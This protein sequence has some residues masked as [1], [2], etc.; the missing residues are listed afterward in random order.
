MDDDSE[1]KVGDSDNGL[2]L[3]SEYIGGGGGE[4]SETVSESDG[5]LLS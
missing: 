1:H 3:D 4:E 5:K 2:V